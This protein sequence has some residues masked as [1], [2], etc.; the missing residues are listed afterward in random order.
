[1]KIG[2][3]VYYI[4]E[5]YTL[6]IVRPGK[7]IGGTNYI[8]VQPVKS[9]ELDMMLLS[10]GLDTPSL[11]YSPYTVFFDNLYLPRTEDNRIQ[12]LSIASEMN[13]RRINNLNSTVEDQI[14]ALD[15]AKA[16]KHA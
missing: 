2:D 3:E 14:K 12:L 7:I 13:I 9:K 1:M 11:D 4:D 5:N 15:A 8:D 10:S 6:C 16:R